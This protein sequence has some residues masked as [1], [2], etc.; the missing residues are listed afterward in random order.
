MGDVQNRHGAFFL[1]R[2]KQLQ[3]LGLHRHIQGRGGLVGDDQGRI[4]C[5]GHGNHHPLALP[6]AE[7]MG[8]IIEAFCCRREADILQQLNAALPQRFAFDMFMNLNGLA[9]LIFNGK[10]RIERCQ[11]FLEYHGDMIAANF[12]KIAFAEVEQIFSLKQNFPAG[13]P[14]GWH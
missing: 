8:I 9:D 6:A 13:D 11:R 10:N 12:L 5:Q 1:E 2:L 14:A 7:L 4:A 3:N